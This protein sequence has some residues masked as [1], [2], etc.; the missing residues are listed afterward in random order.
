MPTE[1][2]KK[3][4]TKDIKPILAVK[5]EPTDVFPLAHYVDDKVEIIRQI[6][7]CLKSKTIHSITPDFLQVSPFVCDLFP[8]KMCSYRI[9]CY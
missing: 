6:F 9:A 2:K 8:R 4:A 7:G 5:S 1:H 3:K